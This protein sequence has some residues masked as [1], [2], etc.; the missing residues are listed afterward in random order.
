MSPRLRRN[1]CG[2]LA[3]LCAISVAEAKPPPWHRLQVIL[4]QSDMPG[5]ALAGLPALGITAGRVFGQRQDFSPT[6]LRATVMPFERAGLSV[7]VENV[8]T[9]FFA[10][11]HRWQPGLPI[12][13]AFQTLLARFR[14]QRASAVWQRQPSLADQTALR[15]VEHRLRSHALALAV[16]PILYISLGDETGIADLS[17]ASDLDQTK[18]VLDRWRTGL[19][20]RFGSL[21]ALN[22]AWNA[23]HASWLDVKPT[24]TDDAL[25]GS[26]SIAAWLSFK[27]FMDKLFAEDIARGVAA[28]H[29]GNRGTLAAIEGAQ[30][31]GWGGYDYADLAPATDVIEA[32]PGLPFLLARAFN[33]GITL[34]TTIVPAGA[35]T[36]TTWL[37]LLEGARGLVIWDEHHDVIAPDGS[38]GETG[39]RLA[40]GLKALEGPIGQAL[41]RAKPDFGRVGVLYSPSSF[42]LRWLLDRQA[43]RARGQDWT[44]R[45][46]DLDLSDSPWRAALASSTSALQHLGLRSRI[47]DARQ[48]EHGGLTHLDALILPQSLVLSAREMRT[49]RK[50]ALAGGLLLADDQPGRFDENGTPRKSDALSS[51]VHLIPNWSVDGLRT[52][53]HMRPVVTRADRPISNI[54]AFSFNRGALVAL[55]ADTPDA[56]GPISVRI[57]HSQCTTN[58]DGVVPALIIVERD[59]AFQLDQSGKH[60]AISCELVNTKRQS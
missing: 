34:L 22:A 13:A 12:N 4:W 47:L 45:D 32:G 43:D 7:M 5:P 23:D 30:E 17:A 48:L 51:L 36:N 54:S 29:A 14:S 15:G 52:A 21:A 56:A 24:S 26:G 39:R 28:V 59:H 60:V 42:R 46:N 41:F 16:A 8:A 57:G 33:P 10:A 25:E 38:V 40:T 58:L 1:L 44:T 19:R 3:S 2:L 11:Y 53:L 37:A 20:G 9:D 35:E 49:L 27:A 18:T 6:G 31:P 50:F 55:E